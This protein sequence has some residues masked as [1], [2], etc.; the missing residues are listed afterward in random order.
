MQLYESIRAHAIDFFLEH[1]VDPTVELREIILLS[2]GHYIGRRFYCA[3]LQAVWR[4]ESGELLLII[5]EAEQSRI[6]LSGDQT[7]ASAA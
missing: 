1:G 6:S 2:N 4:P 5:G 3:H 7:T